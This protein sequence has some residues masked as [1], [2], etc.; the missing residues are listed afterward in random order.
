MHVGVDHSG[1]HQV[2]PGLDPLVPGQRARLGYRGDPSLIDPKV[3]VH[4]P[5]VGQDEGA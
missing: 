5:A 3:A 4:Q 1:Q 2:A